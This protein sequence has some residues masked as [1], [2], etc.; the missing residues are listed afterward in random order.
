MTSCWLEVPW[1]QSFGVSC[2]FIVAGV[3]GHRSRLANGASARE[4]CCRMRASVTA[5]AMITVSLALLVGMHA[6]HT[7]ISAVGGQYTRSRVCSSSATLCACNV[8]YRIASSHTSSAVSHSTI[9]AVRLSILRGGT[10]DEENEG[11]AGTGPEAQW[12][13]QAEPDYP[14]FSTQLPPPLRLLLSC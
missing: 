2:P 5:A 3:A 4:W 1:Y 14:G 9:S 13:V 6:V 12:G 7:P 11:S 10:S 8:L